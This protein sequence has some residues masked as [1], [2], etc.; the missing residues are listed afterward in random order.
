MSTYFKKIFV[1]LVIISLISLSCTKIDTDS[2]SSDYTGDL[3]Y[4]NQYVDAVF[5]SEGQFS[6]GTGSLTTLSSSGLVTQDVFRQ[7]ND[8]PIGDVPQSLIEIGDNYYIAVNNSKKI[9]V[10]NK[11]DFTS[12]ETITFS[13][14]YDVIPMYIA[15]LGGDSIAVTDQTYTTG[16]NLYI[17]DINHGE[18]RTE[19]RRQI[20]MPSATFQLKVVNDKL[21]VAGDALYVFDLHSLT[22]EAMRIVVDEY[23]DSFEIC[24]FSKLCLD[25]EGLLWCL[26]SD[27][28]VC[29]DP[30]SESVV[31]KLTKDGISSLWGSI[32]IDNEGENLYFN[33]GSEVYRVDTRNMSINQTPVLIHDNDDDD[34]TT[35]TL[36][37]SKNSTIF[38]VR[39]LY[40]SITRGR[41]FEY[42]TEG[43]I[44]NYYT[45][46]DGERVPYFKAGI[47][48]HHIHFL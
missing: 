17:V 38:I 11:Y 9:E 19:V 41:V 7:A 15:H 18:V 5:V 2:Q 14:S 25:S 39:V 47:F 46:S 12:V 8:R 43:E 33:V 3:T 28:V 42:T 1:V 45:D 48:P 16:A 31:T 4:S 29:V 32:D 44:A 21:F 27:G 20:S 34:W 26:T 37:V 10:V 24:D 35:Y 13:D 36:G 22:S 6:Y 40:G 23:G 30:I